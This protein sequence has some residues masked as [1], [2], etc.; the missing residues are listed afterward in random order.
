MEIYIAAGIL[1]LAGAVLGYAVRTLKM[2]FWDKPVEGIYWKRG[3]PNLAPGECP[4]IPF[5]KSPKPWPRGEK[6][7]CSNPRCRNGIIPCGMFGKD[8]YPCP[9]CKDKRFIEELE[10]FIGPHLDPPEKQMLEKALFHI[11]DVEEQLR[12][13]NEAIRRICEFWGIK[14]PITKEKRSVDDRAIDVGRKAMKNI[15]LDTLSPGTIE[16]ILKEIKDGK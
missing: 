5:V 8:S 6:P 12:F 7:K 4:R 13:C 9:D 10:N 16:K 2:W 1:I 14:L 3:L 15:L 11:K